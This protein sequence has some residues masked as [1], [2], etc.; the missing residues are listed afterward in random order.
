MAKQTAMTTLTTLQNSK[1]D[2]YNQL[3]SEPENEAALMGEHIN[4]LF[5][6]NSNETSNDVSNR[7]N[8]NANKKSLANMSKGIKF[9]VHLTILLSFYFSYVPNEDGSSGEYMMTSGQYCIGAYAGIA[10]LFYW[11][12]YG[13]PMYVKLSGNVELDFSGNYTTEN[14]QNITETDFKYVKNLNDL[15]N[16]QNYIMLGLGA[17]VM[18]GVGICGVLSVRGIVSVDFIFRFKYGASTEE[19][20]DGFLFQLGGGFGI[21]LFI[22]S[23]DYVPSLVTYGTGVYK[24]VKP[25]IAS[26]ESDGQ[27]GE[28]SIRP[29]SR[30][31]SDHNNFGN[32]DIVTLADNANAPNTIRKHS[33]KSKATA[34][35]A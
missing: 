4:N 1:N 10:K 8:Q 5:A 2:A 9:D 25:D 11:T 34:Y 29:L 15:L 14:T 17:Q 22:F 32:S 20:M 6:E 26:L 18:V 21:D 35:N 7:I 12:V 16:P 24:D 3:A 33:R 28:I 31:S 30:G 23:F 27:D 13:V 19:Y